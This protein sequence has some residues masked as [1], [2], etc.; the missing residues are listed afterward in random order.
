MRYDLGYQL[1]MWE[2]YH[3]QEGEGERKCFKIYISKKGKAN[4]QRKPK[5]NAR[6]YCY[7]GFQ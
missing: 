1:R 6:H 2:V 3:V 4:L 5:H 7:S